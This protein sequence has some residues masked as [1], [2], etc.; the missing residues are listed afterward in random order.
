VANLNVTYHEMDQAANRL[1][2]GQH[3]IEGQLQSLQKLVE[4][5]VSGG[6]VTDSSSKA[7]ETSYNEFNKGVGDVIQ[8]LTGMSNYLKKAASTFSDADTQLASALKG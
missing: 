2:N 5:L 1:T 6:Y 7:F 4:S 8:G 3:E